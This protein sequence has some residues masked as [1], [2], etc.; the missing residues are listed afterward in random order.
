MRFNFSN[1]EA[2]LLTRILYVEENFLQTE[3][4]QNIPT[5]RRAKCILKGNEEYQEDDNCN[6]K[7]GNVGT[8]KKSVPSTT[9]MASVFNK[10]S[11]GNTCCDL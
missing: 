10:K 7:A 9:V 6:R 4:H 1:E 3:S 5:S 8:N 2:I 11:K